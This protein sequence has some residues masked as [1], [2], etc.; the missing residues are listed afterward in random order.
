MDKKSNDEKINSFL[1]YGWIPRLDREPPIPLQWFDKTITSTD[2]STKRGANIL[3]EAVTHCIGDTKE[4]VIPISG[5]LDSRVILAIAHELNCN[6]TAITV[7]T[8]GTYDFEYGRMVA[9]KL[10]VRHDAIDVTKLEITTDKLVKKAR[11][12][13]DWV[14]ITEV[15][16]NLLAN[17]YFPDKK[18]ITGLLGDFVAGEFAHK[19]YNSYEEAK[20]AFAQDTQRSKNAPL[21]AKDF[22]ATKVLPDSPG[23]TNLNYYEDIV[24]RARHTCTLR[25]NVFAKNFNYQS[26]FRNQAWVEYMMSAPP[27]ARMHK[28][29]YIEI[30]NQYWPHVFSLPSKNG[31][32]AST[33]SSAITQLVKRLQLRSSSALRNRLP[34]LQSLLGPDPMVNYFNVNEVLHTDTALRNLLIENVSDLQKRNILQWLDVEQLF[35]DVFTSTKSYPAGEGNPRLVLAN[36]EINLKSK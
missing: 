5:G 13:D 20:V 25:P 35:A 1:H 2:H 16:F 8:P 31:F 15:Y 10:G 3:R 18:I 34:A 27:T 30:L 32:G 36:L 4:V 21:A 6:I 12:L 22:D 24:L 7:G 33:K 14:N 19:N 23:T 28:K 29:L 17:T 26:P 11:E 9:E